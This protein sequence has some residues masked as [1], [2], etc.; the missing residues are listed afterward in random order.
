MKAT[1][2]DPYKFHKR[3]ILILIVIIIFLNIVLIYVKNYLAPLTIV[4]DDARQEVAAQ[5]VINYKLKNQII[6]ARSLRYI[7]VEAKLSGFIPDPHHDYII[8]E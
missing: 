1:L 5:Q 6:E 8:R 7:E 2:R 4:L 3:L